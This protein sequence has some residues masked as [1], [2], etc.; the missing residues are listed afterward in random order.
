MLAACTK[1]LT[2]LFIALSPRLLL[3]LEEAEWARN[4]EVDEWD[5]LTPS[6]GYLCVFGMVNDGFFEGRVEILAVLKV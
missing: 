5:E 6:R 2:P 3:A 4:C 1:Q